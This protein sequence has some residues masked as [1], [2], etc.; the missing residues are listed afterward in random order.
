MKE[1]PLVIVS[2]LH[3]NSTVALCSPGC[4]LVDDG[5][6]ELNKPQEWLWGN[7]LHFINLIPKGAPCIINGDIVQGVHAQ[8]DVQII[9][10]SEKVQ[11]DMAIKT[12]E[13]LAQ[14]VG[15]LYFIRGTEYHD[16]NNGDDIEQVAANFTNTV[17]DA[18]GN[19]SAWEL[20]IEIADKLIYATHHISASKAN[21]TTPL[22]KASQELRALHF[23]RKYPLPDLA[24]FSH[25]HQYHYYADGVPNVI[26][27]PAWQLKNSYVY[28]RMPLVYPQIGGV[29][30]W[31][32]ENG[33]RVEP[34][35]YALPTPSIRQA[36]MGGQ[37][38]TLSE[39]LSNPTQAQTDTLDENCDWS[40]DAARDGYTND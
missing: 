13:P 16:K 20:Y 40:L 28:K 35:R 30:L 18:N 7:W 5:G 38:K 27:T 4:K 39:R 37:S 9:T 29:I 12:I 22:F 1:T 36:R 17:K 23:E 21:P 26:S 19:C 2:D 8:R 15:E 6:Y 14:K 3:V 24:V 11:R 10:A 34:H 32:S 31:I 33:I 25:V